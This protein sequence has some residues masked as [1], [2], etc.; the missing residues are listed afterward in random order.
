MLDE[1][2]GEKFEEVVSAFA[3]IVLRRFAVARK[4]ARLELAS[5][6]RLTRQQQAQ[7]LPLIIA[8]RRSL[9]K[10][11]SRHRKIKGQAEVYRGILAD[12]HV[13]V[14]YRRSVLSK[15]PVPE[16][17][18]VGGIR[19]DIADSWVGNERWAEILL[20][21]PTR[22]RDRF[23]EDAFET[24]WKAVQNGED[25]DFG[26][27]TDL[28]ENLDARIAS[29]ETRLRNWKTLLASL[30]HAQAQRARTLP[31]VI[32]SD[33]GKSAMPQFD[34]HQSLHLPD[35]PLLAPFVQHV[36]PTAS[37]HKVLLLS[38]EAEIDTLGRQK[39]VKSD[40]S[41]EVQG[42][43]SGKPTENE[44]MDLARFEHSQEFL[45]SGLRNS[46]TV[47]ICK[48]GA[49]ESKAV[50][51]AASSPRQNSSALQIEPI[52]VFGQHVESEVSE[53]RT[54]TSEVSE[55]GFPQRVGD[56]KSA[57]ANVSRAPPK[58][59]DYQQ[60]SGTNVISVER[61]SIQEEQ[62][63]PAVTPSSLTHTTNTP[64]SLP[65]R[66]HDEDLEER[67][68]L[69]VS[70]HYVTPSNTAFESATLEQRSKLSITRPSTLLERTR[71]SMSLIPNPKGGAGQGPIE[72][73]ALAKQERLSHAVPVS[74][75]GTPRIMTE[76]ESSRLETTIPKLGCSTPRDELFSDAAAYHSVFKSRPRIALSPAL[77]PDCSGMGLDNFLGEPLA[78]LTLDADR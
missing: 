68:E 9:Q 10:Q 42:T 73:R 36:V 44:K 53:S 59:S 74:Q 38:M 28:L 71:Q 67:T 3:M 1:C 34:R 2:K 43:L 72:E 27:Q 41:R 51:P 30:Q 12:R 7:I 47:L 45:S 39:P 22:P 6:D 77:S 26:H 60:S 64:T 16:D 62:E 55:T 57:R 15:L 18:R 29:Q 14:E 49:L 69:S 24:G 8:H 48:R 11:L 13:S 63:K 33:R 58:S 52:S 75:Y 46:P 76:P 25:V 35:N 17:R 5:S 23:L 19:E 37:V 32:P 54:P 21:G 31:T 61:L 20:S 50:S 78:D 4:D 65:A 66:R 56:I 70:E 40:A